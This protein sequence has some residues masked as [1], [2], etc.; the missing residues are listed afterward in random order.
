MLKKYLS[1]VLSVALI[2]MASA[3]TVSAK[4]KAEKEAQFAEK[5]KAGILKLGTGEMA[6]VKV[7]LRDKT[8]LEGFISEAGADSFTVVDTKTGT[9]TIV[10]YPQVDQVKGNNLD[11]G[12]KIMIGFAIAVLIFAVIYFASMSPD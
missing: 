7:K 4:S 5:V 9:T 11:T 12:T 2:H 1:V 8:K 6:R 3:A 10:G